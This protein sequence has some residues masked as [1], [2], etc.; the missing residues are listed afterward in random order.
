MDTSADKIEA[1]F[2]ALHKVTQA[3]KEIN[4]NT[5]GYNSCRKMA[6][7]VANNINHVDNCIHYN[8]AVLMIE[9]NIIAEREQETKKSSHE[10][11]AL[12]QKTE[13]NLAMIRNA[14]KDISVAVKEIVEGGEEVNTSTS[15][16]LCE[17]QEMLDTTHQLEKITEVI[18]EEMNAFA[19]A[20]AQ[21]IEI[22]EQTNLLSL[23]ASIEAARAGELGK[24]FVIVAS[25]VKKLSENSKEVAKSTKKE[26][27]D[28]INNVSA[29]LKIAEELKNKI[30][31]INE[32]MINIS[33][34]IEEMTAKT[35]D[36]EGTASSLVQY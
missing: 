10:I 32:E 23:N 27:T 7:A 16:I 31:K 22:S 15:G 30:R 14:V 29:L 11:E 18:K 3:D 36:V 2:K 34:A 6:E 26:E 17:S 1:A 19:N 20:S 25:E 28:I 4:C 9:N 5:C 12:R 33:A 8:K 35:M 24:G 13:D 21:I